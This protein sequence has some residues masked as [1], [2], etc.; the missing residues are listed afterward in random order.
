M[1]WCIWKERNIC[2]SNVDPSVDHCKA[3]FKKEFA[4]II[5]RAEEGWVN[6]M[7]SWRLILFFPLSFSFL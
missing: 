3:V 1:T 2:F 6:D 5:H 7:K 4:L